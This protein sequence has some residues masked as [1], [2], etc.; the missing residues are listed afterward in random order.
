MLFGEFGHEV[1]R[2]QA[3]DSQYHAAGTKSAELSVA[4]PE[5][6][7]EDVESICLLQPW[8]GRTVAVPPFESS[9]SRRNKCS[10]DAARLFVD[11]APGWQDA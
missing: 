7:V 10:T 3:V 1:L 5:I 9:E 4:R 11:E 8:I 6:E 2:G